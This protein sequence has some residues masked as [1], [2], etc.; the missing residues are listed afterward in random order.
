MLSK[1]YSGESLRGGHF[2]EIVKGRANIESVHICSQ[3][4]IPAVDYQAEKSLKLF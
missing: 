1:V 3:I 4:S 2:E